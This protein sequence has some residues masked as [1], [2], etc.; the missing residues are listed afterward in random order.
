MSQ[1]M[2]SS[3]LEVKQNVEDVKSARAKRNRD[4]ATRSR[5]QTKEKK[6]RLE[7]ENKIL[8]DRVSELEQ[9][10]EELQ[11]QYMAKFGHRKEFT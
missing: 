5:Q 1:E 8:A 7:S 4:A 3:G 10:H 9:E 2:P 11:R 6:N